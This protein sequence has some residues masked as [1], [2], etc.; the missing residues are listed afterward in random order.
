MV[1]VLA[2]FLGSV[3]AAT[4][5][6]WIWSPGTLR[7][8]VDE[9][10]QPSPQG[11]AEKR[12]VVLNGVDQWLIIK[13]HDRGNP[14]LLYLHG[15]MPDYFLT[16]DFPTGMERHFTVVWWDQR[17]AGL[18]FRAGMTAD[19]VSTEQLV[20]DALRL[21]R[22][23]CDRFGQERI[24]LMGHSGGTVIGALAA[25]R[26]PELF[27]AYIGVAQITDQLR[28]E[29]LARDFMLAACRASGHRRMARRL[30]RVPPL[31]RIPLP[32]DWMAIRDKAMHRLGVG[33]MREIRSVG[34]GL[35]L[36][37][38]R[39]REF[40]MAEKL[41][42]WRGKAMLG[43]PIWNDILGRDLTRDVPR[44]NLPVYLLHGVH[45]HTVSYPL[46]QRYFA[47]LDAP[48]KGF[49]SFAR[50]AHSPLFEEP[51]RFRTILTRDVLTGT[52]SLADCA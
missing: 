45:D 33:T 7:P 16:Q 27:H 11:L 40:T 8:V 13:S 12:P 44:L 25:C 26:E 35:F 31:D 30:E 6:L 18:S 20:D 48:V 9:A 15:G 51:Q 14:L 42:M 32:D 52:V 47:R 49:Y 34:R 17:G 24:Y 21:A 3:A 39:N 5:L 23:L 43:Y 4:L 41:R 19:A 50:S 22:D 46:A 36:R 10:G 37:S 38:L 1:A 28:S 29:A 2:V